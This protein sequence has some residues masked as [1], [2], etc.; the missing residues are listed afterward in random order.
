MT[1]INRL[2]RLNIEIEGLLRVLEERHS[3]DARS[4]LAEKFEDYAA[5]MRAYVGG[6]EP[7]GEFATPGTVEVPEPE[8]YEPIVSN[9]NE[10]TAVEPVVEPGLEPVDLEIKEQE[11][12][13]PELVDETDAATT[14]I[15]LGE[16][17]GQGASRCAGEA[18]LKAFTLNDKF[19]FR[20]ELFAGDDDDFS[21]TLVLLA[22]MPSYE[23]AS[24]YLF[25]DLLWDRRDENVL[26]FME[27]LKAH[28][29][30]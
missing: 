14:A 24:D 6:H 17:K 29:P 18:L 13:E 16:A 10:E 3:D 19:R 21:S 5:L 11:A 26:A 28:M 4:M 22:Q 1:D 15:T 7:L 30:A 8:V 12:V 25:H 27:I 2:I 9:E 20:R 23:E